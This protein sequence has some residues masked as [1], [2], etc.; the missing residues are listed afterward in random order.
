LSTTKHIPIIASLRG[1]SAIAVCLFHLIVTTQNNI[2]NDFLL[3][4]FN[5][6]QKGVQVFFII[7]GIVIPLSMINKK[8]NYS[9]L[10]KFIV[11]RLIRI[12][13]PYL[14]TLLLSIIY[15][16]TRN[17]TYYSENHEFPLSIK[18]IVLNLFYLTA[19][20]ENTKLVLTVFWT[21][22]IEFQYY[23]FIALLL[24][25]ALS[26]KKLIKYAFNIIII[27]FPL[28]LN[29]NAFFPFWTAYFGLGIFYTLYLTKK[30]PL[31]EYLIFSLLSCCV[32]Y[33]QQGIVDL[34]IGGSTL[35]VIHVFSEYGKNKIFT[36]LG[37]ISYS[38]YLT[39]TLT[40][41]VFIAFCSR[42]FSSEISILII[43]LVGILISIGAAYIF[44]L[45]IEKP[46]QLAS[47]KAI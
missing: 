4:F 11:K 6:G 40:G 25:M 35:S 26:S 45:F 15:L 17:Y 13:I 39:H 3:E 27:S 47:K 9:S 7:S 18:D 20:F 24:P 32:I 12:E 33:Y 31:N 2:T 46:S 5:Y 8:Y 14:A 34:I 41:K 28:F 43:V 19:F 10:K 22:A 23:I 36:F 16:Y 29:D 42:L 1:I 38:L 21:L 44:W 30:Y 37:A